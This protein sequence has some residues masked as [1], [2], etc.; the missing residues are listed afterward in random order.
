MPVL[1]HSWSAMYPC[2]RVLTLPPNKSNHN[3]LLI[4]VNAEPFVQRRRSQ[5]FY[6]EEMWAHQQDSTSVIQQGW[7]LPTTGDPMAQVCKKI[8]STGHLLME[9]H[10]GVFQQRRTE[11]K[12]VQDKLDALMGA[13]FHPDQ[14]AEQSALRVRFNELLSLD[15]AYWRQRSRVLWLKDGDRNFAFFSSVS[16]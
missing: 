3:P 12:L 7:T 15:E 5:R 16:F 8:Q 4:E 14:F 13:P 1:F 11:M 10:L 6:F 2:S 9:W